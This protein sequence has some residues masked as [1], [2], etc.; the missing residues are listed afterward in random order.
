MRFERIEKLC[1][2]PYG[3]G[4]CPGGF[5]FAH[6][7][8]LS[9]AR[10]RAA[11]D[12]CSTRARE[13]AMKVTIRA[14]YFDAVRTLRCFELLAGHSV[15]IWNDRVAELE[16]LVE[17]L[18]ETEVLVLIRERTKVS[19][20]LLERLP[21]RRSIGLRS[22]FHTST[23]PRAR[24][25]ASSLVPTCARIRILS[26]PLRDGAGAIR[27]TRWR[28]FRT[29]WPR[30][31]SATSGATNTNRNSPISSGRSSPTLP[32]ARRTWSTPRPFARKTPLQ[33]SCGKRSVC[34]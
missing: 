2:L 3:N 1:H 5:H 33:R 19:A 24:A 10:V 16:P 31:T 27:P 8:V 28:H 12:G 32:A 26:R 6:E 20:E 29:W 17:R 9:S 22:V 11:C 18:G 25:A 4:E 30:R 7:V 34:S 21:N 15:T 14:G 23:W 13:R